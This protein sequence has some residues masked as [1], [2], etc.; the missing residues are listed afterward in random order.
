MRVEEP[1]NDHRLR[2]SLGHCR[3]GVFEVIGAI[4]QYWFEP[5]AGYC[6][7]RLHVVQKGSA[8]RVGGY[9]R[10]ESRD[11]GEGRDDLAE[12]LEAFAAKLCIHTR[13]SREFPARA[14]QPYYKAA[15]D[16]CA[17]RC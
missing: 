12:Q 3:E 15:F 17:T 14:G 4:D 6:R 9:G 11:P 5:D 13:P 2:L 8:E 10:G 7:G 16:R 1:L